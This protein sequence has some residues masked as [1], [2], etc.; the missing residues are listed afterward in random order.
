MNH[1]S[2]TLV[3]V[4]IMTAIATISVG[5]VVPQQALAYHHHHHNHDNGLRVDQQ[6]NQLNNCT[7]PSTQPPPPEIAVRSI[8]QPTVC[9]NEGDNQADIS[10]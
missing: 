5:F 10:K 8:Q 4:S 1:K 2:V 6:I 9:L 7:G 3:I